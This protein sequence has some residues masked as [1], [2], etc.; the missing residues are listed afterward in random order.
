ML[1][2]LSSSYMYRSFQLIANLDLERM[3]SEEAFDYAGN[4]I[5]GWAKHKCMQVFNNLPYRK[6]S[7]ELKRDGTELGV[8]YEPDKGCFILRAMH[9]DIHVPGR[10]WITDTQLTMEGNECIFAVRLSVSSLQSCSESVPFSLPYFVRKIAEAIGISDGEKFST[11]PHIIETQDDVKRFVEYLESADRSVPV[12]LLTPCN[13]LQEGTYGSFMLEADLM[14]QNLFGFA[15]I[16]KITKEANAMLDELVGRQWSAFNGAVRTYY[17]GLSFLESDMYQHPLLTRQ[18]IAIR[19]IKDDDGIDGCMYA[20][21]EYIQKFVKRRIQWDKRNIQFYLAARQNKLIEAR[22]ESAQSTEKLIELYEAQ[23]KQE[24]EKSDEYAALADSYAYDYE[25]CKTENEQLRRLLGHLKNRVTY[26]QETLEAISGDADD[27]KVPLNGTY[28]DVSEWVEKYYPGRIMLT[29]RAIHSLK[30]AC[31][32]DTELVYKCLKLLAT[33]YY[34]YKTGHKTY[35]DFIQECKAVDSGLEERGA[36]TDVAAGMEGDT[37]FVQY[38]GKRRMLERHLAKGSN[39]DRRY[40][41]RIYFFWD[42]E[43]QMVVIGDLP[44]HLDTAAT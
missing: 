21:K 2:P 9:P 30:D 1:T 42:A 28:S 27:Q 40:C 15:H 25:T 16:Y 12:V 14:A 44:H 24:Q 22:Q 32:S 31:Y 34:D 8:I 13:S 36:I 4:L 37:Y 19:N 23:L 10:I 33:S 5:Y 38:R 20:V 7:L 3:S 39:K 35:Q 41:L 43:D 6:E 26:L 29:S 17:P 18:A 11:Y